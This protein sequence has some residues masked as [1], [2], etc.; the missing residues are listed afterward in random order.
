VTPRNYYLTKLSDLTNENQVTAFDHPQ[1]DLLGVT[2]D[3]TCN[4][5][6]PANYDGTPRPTVRHLTHL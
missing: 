5:Y 3:L 2:I 4:V 6:L 1:P